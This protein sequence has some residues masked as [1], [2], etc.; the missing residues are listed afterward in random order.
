MNKE[1]N[2]QN[3]LYEKLLGNSQNLDE[4]LEKSAKKICEIGKKKKT[5]HKV[6]SKNGVS[7]LKL[8]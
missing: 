2:V 3:K 4:V 5:V 8:Y 1:N 6:V 7:S